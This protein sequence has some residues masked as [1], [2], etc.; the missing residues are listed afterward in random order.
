MTIQR[1]EKD[2]FTVYKA[3]HKAQGHKR[4]HVNLVNLAYTRVDIETRNT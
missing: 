3:I 1:R 2:L 4:G